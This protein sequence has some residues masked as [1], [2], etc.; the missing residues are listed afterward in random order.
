MNHIIYQQSGDK[1]SFTE[2]NILEGQTKQKS[3]VVP[4]DVTENRYEWGK[5]L[6]DDRM[7]EI[8]R[9]ASAGLSSVGASATGVIYSFNRDGV[10]EL[11][12]RYYKHSSHSRM[13]FGLD[14]GMLVV[15][16]VHTSNCDSAFFW[17]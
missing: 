5:L 15:C 17:I 3:K 16:I 14:H 9:V 11:Q 2:C 10:I 6:V 1:N 8:E 4:V 13:I 12:N 7:H